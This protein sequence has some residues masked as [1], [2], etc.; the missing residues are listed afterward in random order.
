[1]SS[2][3]AY[4]L[5]NPSITGSQNKI[6]HSKNPY[7]AG[8]KFYNEL[9]EHFTNHMENFYMTV[10]NVETGKLSH[11]RIKEKRNGDTID[12]FMT[13]LPENLPSSV[14]KKLVEESM[15]I[16][17]QEGGRHHHRSD[18]SPS[19]SSSDSSSS[20]STSMEYHNMLPITRF[21]YFNLPY[22]KLL[23]VDQVC[24]NKIYLPV[25]TLPLSPTVE[26]SFDVY[27]F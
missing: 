16:E 22:Y 23:N 17:K 15:K 26:V 20:D 2:K 19:S 5:I 4:R 11:Y 27:K 21:V 13:I 12:F 7:N 6:I 10:M 18:D 24:C 3:N 8:K 14:E 25:F 9:S 1:M